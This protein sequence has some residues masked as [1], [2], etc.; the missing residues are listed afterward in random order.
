MKFM[1]FTMYDV[2]K[3]AEVMQAS[4]KA[5][6]VPGQ[7]MLAVYACLG[8]AFDGMPP[9]TLLGIAIRD[10]ENSEALAAVMYTLSLAGATTWAVPV[11]E[12]PVGDAATEEK[13]LRK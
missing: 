2:A 4:D 9:N 11:L 13:K 8:K 12:V 1:L 5:A 3:A 6:K 10:A 7:K